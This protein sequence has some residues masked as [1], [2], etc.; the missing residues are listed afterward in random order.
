MDIAQNSTH[1]GAHR[2]DIVLAAEPESGMLIL[3]VKDDGK[4]MDADFLARV[5]DPFTTTRTTRKVGLG[6]P[7]LKLAAG[8]AG[9]T[10]GITSEPGRGT[11]LRT[12]F[13]LDNIDRI[14][15]GDI[16]GTVAALMTAWTDIEWAL[17]LQ[18]KKDRFDLATEEI[19]EILE[20]VPI[21]SPA[22]A[23]WIGETVG[24]AMTNVFGGILDEVAEGS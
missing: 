17:H 19:K 12:T 4:G 7:L 23:G 18:S 24:E 15:V 20:G 22:V 10:L 16:A 14:P 9:G 11:T 13:R 5:T 21:G 6:I 1:A 2:V 8:L 3:T